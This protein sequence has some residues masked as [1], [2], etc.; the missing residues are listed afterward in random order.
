MD[1]DGVFF[2]GLDI[3]VFVCDCECWDGEVV[4]DDGEYNKEVD[5]RFEGLDKVVLFFVFFI[6]MGYEMMGMFEIENGI[7]VN[8]IEVFYK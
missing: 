5:V 3:Y 6:F 4:D 2:D 8:G 7:D 1:F